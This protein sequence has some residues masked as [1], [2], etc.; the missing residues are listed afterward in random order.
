VERRKKKIYMREG[1]KKYIKSRKR[2]KRKSK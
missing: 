2:E 1:T